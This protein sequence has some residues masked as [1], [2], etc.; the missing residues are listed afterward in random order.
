MFSA[1]EQGEAHAL[2]ALSVG[3]QMNMGRVNAAPASSNAFRGPSV[4]DE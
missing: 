1:E 3:P 4:I 2:A